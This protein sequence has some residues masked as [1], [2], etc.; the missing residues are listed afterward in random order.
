MRTRKLILGQANP[1]YLLTNRSGGHLCHVSVP[2]QIA[3]Y[4]ID[5]MC[6]GIFAGS[7]RGLS[8]RSAFPAIHQYE[9]SHGTVVGGALMA[10]PGEGKQQW[11]L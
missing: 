10:K 9:A 3:D 2:H 1:F 11:N 7:A 5:P 6:R 8:M 4:V